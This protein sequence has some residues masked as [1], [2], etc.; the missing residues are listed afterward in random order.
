M[1]LLV[2]D[3][4]RQV[5][6]GI[7]NSINWKDIS[8][9]DDVYY[10]YN[11]FEAKSYFLNGS[12]DILVSDIEMPGESGLQLLSWVGANFPE[13]KCIMLTAHASFG[14]AQDALRLK[15][16]D[17]I[18]QPVKYETLFEAVKKAVNLILQENME[19]SPGRKNQLWDNFHKDVEALIL[20]DY[21]ADADLP[22]L[23]SKAGQLGLPL[24]EQ[25]AYFLL[26]IS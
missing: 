7:R 16:I 10:A 6:D 23:L 14:Y 25:E 11:A 2:V 26:L 4:Q 17:Y 24:Y 5:I 13:T 12:V 20:K 1:N 8:E 18:L 19:R 21:M 9:I 15:A 3:D 22:K